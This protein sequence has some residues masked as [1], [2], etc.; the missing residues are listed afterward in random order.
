MDPMILVQSFR[1]LCVLPLARDVDRVMGKIH[2]GFHLI[3]TVV[4]FFANVYDGFFGLRGKRLKPMRRH[5]LGS[6]S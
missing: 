1:L 6:F 2:V 4:M 5:A 3:L